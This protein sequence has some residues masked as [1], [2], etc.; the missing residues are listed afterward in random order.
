MLLVGATHALLSFMRTPIGWA[1]QD[2]ATGLGADLAVWLGHT[3]LMAAFFIISGLFRRGGGGRAGLRG[4]LRHRGRRLLI[5][6]LAAL[7]PTMFALYRL[8][9]VGEARA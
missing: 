6:Y 3:F 8:W 5:P 4:F 1:I 9:D 7:P 2:R